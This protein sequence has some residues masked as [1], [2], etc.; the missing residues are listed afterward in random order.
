MFI[1]IVTL[2][3]YYFYDEYNSRNFTCLNLNKT[4]HGEVKER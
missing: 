1:C 4:Y 2:K 3:F